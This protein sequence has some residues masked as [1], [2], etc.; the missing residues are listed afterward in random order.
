MTWGSGT[1][2]RGRCGHRGSSE[3]GLTLTVAE[4]HR[5]LCLECRVGPSGLCECAVVVLASLAG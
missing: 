3:E 5:G 4:I 1:G 2:N